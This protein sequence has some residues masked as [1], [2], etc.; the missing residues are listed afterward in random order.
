MH[1]RRKPGYQFNRIRSISYVIAELKFDLSR[2]YLSTAIEHSKDTSQ[3]HLPFQS[4]LWPLS[5]SVTGSENR[6]PVI[7]ESNS[8]LNQSEE[9]RLILT[10]NFFNKVNAALL[11]SAVFVL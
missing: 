7:G 2:E 8:H 5:E 3:G 10:H 6:V 9:K 1:L 11:V 4:E